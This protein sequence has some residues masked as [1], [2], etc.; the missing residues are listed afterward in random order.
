[1]KKI[2]VILFIVVQAFDTNAQHVKSSQ[3]SIGVFYD[4]LFS[5]MKKEY[6]Y[7][8]KIQWPELEPKIRKNLL[9]YQ[10]FKSSLKEIT[11]IFDFSKATHC[12]LF[13][14]E[15][16][17]SATYDGPSGKD[18]S[19]QWIKKYASNPTFEVKI[20]DNQYGYILMPSINFEDISKEN[21][22][23]VSQ[24]LY[25]EISKVENSK[26]T[27][28]WIIDLRFNSGGNSMPM[29]LALYDFLG[30]NVVY[31]TL[32]IDKKRI[33]TTKLNKGNYLDND[34]ITSYIKIKS[35]K[36][37][38]TKVAIITGIITASSGE[39]TALAFKGRKNTFYVGEPTNG[40]TT[41]NDKR[42]LPFGAFMALTI[43]YDCDRNGV[44]YDKI[45]PDVSLSKQD[46][47]DNLLLDK[48]IQE[49]IKFIT[50]QK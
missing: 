10:Y 29:L 40:R 9:Q 28:G 33:N 44:F 41:T 11:Q 48:N 46:N 7:K 13:Y 43:G 30:D 36:L 16:E 42:L 4:T 19:E 26:K 2:L 23:K 20:L 15:N 34:T 17:F 6:L 22:H 49:A 21:I 39:I 1:M 35:K 14:G 5:V 37:T 18:F 32:D 45:V 47:F 50:K 38:E 12:T 24:P 3:D 25:D 27:K 31:G 8:D